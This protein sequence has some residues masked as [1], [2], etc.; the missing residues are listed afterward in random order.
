MRGS[1]GTPE[2]LELQSLT[3]WFVLSVSLC[4]VTRLRCFVVLHTG[5]N[6]SVLG[7]S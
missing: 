3:F 6:K 2:L 4:L 7:L 5:G 1:R